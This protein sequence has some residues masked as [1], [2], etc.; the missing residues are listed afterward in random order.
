M[1][2]YLAWISMGFILLQFLVALANFLF[3]EKMEGLGAS[4]EERV[5]ILIPARNEE[6][7]IET[8]ISD[9][10][11]QEYEN[12]EL[13]IYND[14][15]TDRTA[16]IVSKFEAM[17]NRIRM[18]SSEGLPGGWLGKNHACHTLARH[19]SGKYYLFLDAD[20]R[21]GG[22]IIEQAM[23][24]AKKRRLS[25]ITIFPKQIMI[26]R[27]EKISVPVM[28]YILLTLLPLILVR[29][30]RNPS[31]AA[32]NGQFM[33]FDA[34]TYHRFEP[35]LM[36]KDQRVEDIAIARLLKVNRMRI[37]CQTGD[38]RIS[39]RMYTNYRDAL[40]GFTKNIIEYF[41]G[42][43]VLA[44]L[45]WLIT[46]LGIIFVILGMPIEKIIIF[47]IVYLLTRML[48]SHRSR[49]NILENIIFLLHQQ[50]VMGVFIAT[51]I[52][53]SAGKSHEWKGR[54]I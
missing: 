7:H 46:T 45:F 26:S 12:F 8:I 17:D 52:R 2:E 41:G 38:D 42:S 9:V 25:L 23:L 14:E 3:H 40:N 27:G 48:V 47:I 33:F 13:L 5:S 28:T 16:E 34:K 31:L 20:V 44:V 4:L 15:S 51:A 21:I 11:D 24:Y 30:S 1:I 29:I 54:K 43:S 32:A 37:S 10:L 6:D 19:A 22:D 50:F 35:H 39:C 36:V 49:Q 18:I 53:K